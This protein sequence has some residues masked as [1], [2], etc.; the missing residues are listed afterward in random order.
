DQESQTPASPL[1][2]P[3]LSTKLYLSEVPPPYS[4]STI[5][6]RGRITTS[7]TFALGE[8]FALQ[9]NSVLPDVAVEPYVIGS[10]IPNGEVFFVRFDFKGPWYMCQ[11]TD[12]S[13][14]PHFPYLGTTQAGTSLPQPPG[15]ALTTSFGYAYQI[16][17]LPR[18]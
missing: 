2:P 12:V 13:G 7:A 14:V 4:G 10:L 16:I 9:P 1:W 17:R 5:G 6:A 3:K 8:F 18:R 15:A 11:R